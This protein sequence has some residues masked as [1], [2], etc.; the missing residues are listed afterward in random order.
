MA[1]GGWGGGRR[2][3]HPCGSKSPATVIVTPGIYIRGV[4]VHTVVVHGRAAAAV[5]DK[6]RAAVCF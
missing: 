1:G 6:R 3:Q 4:I 2:H 5:G